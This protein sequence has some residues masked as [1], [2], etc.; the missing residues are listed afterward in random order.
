[1][2]KK[3]T[4]S[5]RVPDLRRRAK[6]LRQTRQGKR[7]MVK[8]KPI[9]ILLAEDDPAHAEA[10]RLAF[11]GADPRIVIQTAGTLG[12]YRRSAADHPPDIAI[13]DLSL[14]DG[15]AMEVLKRPPEAGPFPILIMTSF[16]NERT[17]VEAMKA[18]AIDYIV[19]SPEAFADMPRAVERAL[20]EWN[21]RQGRKRAEISLRQSLDQIDLLLN[22]SSYILYRCEAFGDFDATYISGNIEHILGYKPDDFLRKG[23][24]ASKIHPEDAPRVFSE[25]HQLFERGSQKHEYRFQ[26]RDGS[27][28]WIY[29]ELKLTRDEQG[30]P[31]DIF[32]GMADISERKRAGEALRLK[33][34]V[35]EA[36][37]AASAIADTKGVVTEANSAFL[38]LWGYPGKKE[39]IGRPV[40]D[41]LLNKDEAA[42]YLAAINATGKWEGEYT[43]KRKDGTTFIAHG[44]ATAI[45]DE[46]GKMIGYHTAVLDISERK[47]AE[48]AVQ[49]AL[50]EKEVLLKEIHHR[51]KNNMQVISSLFNL[52]AAHIKDEEARR[53][54]K[55]GQTRIRSMGLVHE[56]LY[57]SRDLS[58]IDFS[59]YMRSLLVHLFHAYSIDVNQIRLETELEDVRL[60]INAAVP[61]GLLVNELISNALKH[62]FPEGR[63]GVVKIGLRRREDG[64]VELRVA[65]NGVGFPEKLDFRRTESLGLQIANL[66]IGQLEG[67][68]KIERKRGTA[69]VIAF[70]ESGLKP[71][72]A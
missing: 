29:D 57:Q 70:Q 21:L 47:R 12:E 45:H 41:F 33:N 5:G 19:K 49:A 34:I 27:W 38:N 35:F 16:G 46:G 50:R 52:Q 7:A 67:T 54:L 28:R 13:L 64:A 3:K 59:D 6:T 66:L 1:M 26:H 58:K 51:V 10:I 11:R 56:K 65:D 40:S 17:A 44:Q 55:D 31:K 2:T 15:R 32:G 68:I 72:T 43:A 18:G 23:F 42:A 71:K 9:L 53:I 69:V 14:R 63:K 60:D 62:A 37:I 61:C 20:R 48:E 36:S 25:L 4:R 30:N 8:D 39:I 22:V 24:W